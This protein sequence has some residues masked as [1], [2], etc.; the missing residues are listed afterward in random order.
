[1]STVSI[2]NPVRCFCLFVT[3]RT[4]DNILVCG[5]YKSG[6][7]VCLFHLHHENLENYRSNIFPMP[8]DCEMCL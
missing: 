4:D 5:R 8:L 1:M 7:M 2:R 3:K 6:G